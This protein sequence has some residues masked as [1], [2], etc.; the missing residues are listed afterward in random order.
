MFPAL[1]NSV[2][3]RSQYSDAISAK[4]FSDV[5]SVLHLKII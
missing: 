4:Q 1:K 3:K 5:I 2:L